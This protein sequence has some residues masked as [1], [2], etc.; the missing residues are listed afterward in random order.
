M[1]THRKI[2]TLVISAAALAF[3]NATPAQTPNASPAPVMKAVIYHDYGSPDVLTLQ[4]IPKPVPKDDQVLIKVRAA[5]L[6]PYDWHFMTGMPY[7]MRAGVGLLRPTDPRLGVDFS[8]TVEAVGKNVTT[9]KP[10]DDVIGAKGGAFAEYVCG[11]DK[12]LIIKPANLTFEEGAA[13]PIA[14]L[15]ALLAVRKEAN[16]QPG[17][18]VLINGASGGVGTFAV[19]IAKLAGA[20]VTGVCSTKN[21]E[22]VRS[23]GADKVIDYTKEDFT[24]GTERYD[25]ILDNVANRSLAE[26]RRALTPN[27]K[28]IMIGGPNGTWLKP[29]D[30][31]FKAAFLSR[32]VSQK[33][34][35]MLSDPTPENWA[36]MHDLLASGK[37]KSVIDRRYPLSQIADAMRYLEQGHARGKVIVTL[38]PAGET[39]PPS[40]KA[41]STALKPASPALVL[42]QL[43]AFLGGVLVAP[44]ILALAL[45]RRFKSRNPEKRSYRWGYYFSIM[46]F[47]VVL[48]LSYLLLESIGAVIA[49]AIL[50]AVLAWFFAQRQRWA[51]VALTILSFNPIAWIINGIYLWKR[52]AEPRPAPATV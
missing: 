36:A 20:E 4:N 40:S 50:Y 17:Q 19:Q 3:A 42:F 49:V 35:M 47:I 18:K 2:P 5:S 33:M 44:I 7:I 38:E 8:G 15:T 6:N 11:S 13:V 21:I 46:S 52:W 27:G 26:C 25:V 43:G 37:V 16:V 14:G 12:G 9:F 10:G 48:G 22:L 28:Y 31:V 34:T 24:A 39:A 51:W 32:F 29:M 23:L 41:P 1:K 30:R 45:N